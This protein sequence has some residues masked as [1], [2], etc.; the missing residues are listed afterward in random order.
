MWCVDSENRKECEKECFESR[1][2]ST[3]WLIKLLRQAWRRHV[4]V[5]E[6]GKMIVPLTEIWSWDGELVYM[7]KISLVLSV[8]PLECSGTFLNAQPHFSLF[9]M[10]PKA[11]NT[12]NHLLLPEYTVFKILGAFK[13]V[14]L[15]TGDTCP[16]ISPLSSSQALPTYLS[17]GMLYIHLS[18]YILNYL[19]HSLSNL[20]VKTIS[21]L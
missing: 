18:H 10:Q 14:Q 11:P 13:Y 8:L 2:D 3:W 15:S 5:L 21:F 20:M 1:N 19:L 4:R 12:R 9:P 16:L 6:V 7:E 17:N